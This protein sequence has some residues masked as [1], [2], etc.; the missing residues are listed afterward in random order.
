MYTHLRTVTIITVMREREATSLQ[1]LPGKNRDCLH[2]NLLVEQRAVEGEGLV[3]PTL[4]AHVDAILLVL[5]V[6]WKSH[7]Q[8]VSVAQERENRG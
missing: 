3:L 7:D 6:T 5:Q 1:R 8:V 4:T 2:D